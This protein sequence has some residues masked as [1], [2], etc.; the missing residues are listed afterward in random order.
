MRARRADLF[1]RFPFTV[2]IL[3]P[4]LDGNPQPPG[5]SHQPQN[6][7]DVKAAVLE[8]GADI[9]LAFDGDA[10]RVLL[11][12]EKAEPVSASLTTALVA[13]SMLAKHPGETIL[14][15]LIC[16]H[17]VPEVV[18]RSAAIPYAPVGHSIIEKVMAE[19]GPFRRETRATTTTATSSGHWASSPRSWSWSCSPRVTTAVQM[20]EAYQRYV[21]SVRSTP[22]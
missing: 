3:F 8:H 19:T 20:L 16:S 14:Y 7:V 21:D 18:R 12:D 10:D 11:V 4:E 1:E 6:L 9:E 15:N 13:A 17:V 22:P 5:R 2:D